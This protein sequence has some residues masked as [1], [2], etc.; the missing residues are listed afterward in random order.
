LPLTTVGKAAEVQL[1]QAFQLGSHWLIGDA[2]VL[3]GALV[4]IDQ[5]TDDECD[6]GIPSQV[7][8]LSRYVQRVEEDLQTIRHDNAYDRRLRSKGWRHRGLDSD[9][10][11]TPSKLVAYFGILPIEASSGVDRDGTPRGPK[12]FVM[13]RRGNPGAPGPLP[14]DG[15]AVR[16][17]L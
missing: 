15:R 13:S 11:E 5:A 6:L 12:R 8:D 14:V 9:R 17:P 1:L 16:D 10:F 4:P 3:H 2:F 7:V